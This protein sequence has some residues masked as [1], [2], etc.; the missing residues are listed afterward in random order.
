VVLDSDMLRLLVYKEEVDV[1]NQEPP[2]TEINLQLLRRV[3]IL[4]KK[5]GRRCRARVR[6][7]ATH[8][9]CASMGGAVRVG[10]V[11]IPRPARRAELAHGPC[12]IDLVE[13]SGQGHCFLADTTEM[14]QRWWRAINDYVEQT[15]QKVARAL[16]QR[17][18]PGLVFVL[19]AA[20][21]RARRGRRRFSR[22]PRRTA[23]P[24][25]RSRRAIPFAIWMTF[26]T[27][28]AA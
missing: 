25:T 19:T 4:D 24:P 28:C 15:E 22:R 7:L 23:R 13:Q 11:I 5:G 2:Q 9:V 21:G 6:L 17:A 16:V 14:A 1:F 12:R 10:V 18:R 26:R 20:D 27:R 8:A 3:D